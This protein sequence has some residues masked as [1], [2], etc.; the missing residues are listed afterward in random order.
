LWRCGLWAPRILQIPHFRNPK[1]RRLLRV[2]QSGPQNPIYGGSKISGDPVQSVFS[3]HSGGS[4]TCKHSHE[5]TPGILEL[6][7]TGVFTAPCHLR[8]LS[9]LKATTVVVGSLATVPPKDR[10]LS[11]VHDRRVSYE[12][13]FRSTFVYRL[14]LLF[15]LNVLSIWAP[16]HKCPR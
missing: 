16:G 6:K 5:L 2:P 8:L 12:R 9:H 4:T 13:S 1:G 15:S 14:E 3:E 11:P 7:S 10:F